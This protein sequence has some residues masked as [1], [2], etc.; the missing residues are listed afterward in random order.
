MNSWKYVGWGMMVFLLCFMVQAD[1]TCISCV[2]CTDAIA[3]ANSSD[4]IT[5]S[6]PII[7]GV[8]CIDI[9]GKDN[10]TFDCQGNGIEGDGSPSI[11]ALYSAGDAPNNI[12]IKNCIISDF[13]R[14]LNLGNLENSIIK[15]ISIN[16][17]AYGIYL[18]LSENNTISNSTI[19][20]STYGMYIKSKSFNNTFYDMILEDNAVGVTLENSTSTFR[21]YNNTFYNNFFNNTLNVNS[22]F[23][24][25]TN[26]WNISKTLGN[27]I[28]GGAYLGG[29]F[30]ANPSGKGWSENC[31]AET[32]GLCDASY[33]ATINNT[34]YLPLSFPVISTN[35]TLTIHVNDSA[36]DLENASVYIDAIM[37]LT[38][39]TGHMY[40]SLTKM[41]N[42]SIS[43]I[44]GGYIAQDTT[45]NLTSD[46]TYNFTLIQQNG[47]LPNATEFINN[48]TTDLNYEDDLENV[49]NLT[50]AT[51][52]AKIQFNV[53]VNVS[54]LDLDA[55]INITS[56]VITI[57]ST[58]LVNLN[59][60][61]ILTFRNV[62]CPV[63]IIYYSVVH[64]TNISTVYQNGSDCEADGICTNKLC[65][66][67]TLTF[68][69]AH[70]SSF[71]AGLNSNLTIWDDSD[72]ITI[73]ETEQNKFYANYTNNTIPIN[74]TGIYCDIEFNLTGAWQDND[75]MVFNDTSGLYEYNRSFTTDGTY[76]FQVF[77]NASGDG[78]GTLNTTDSF[79]IS[80]VIVP[81]T[82]GYVCQAG[83]E[84]N[85]LSGALLA[86]DG[87][88][89]HLVLNGSE[90][91]EASDLRFEYWDDN[92][93]AIML[94]TGNDSV[95][96]CNG[97]VLAGHRSGRA[98]KVRNVN[99]LSIRD[100]DVHNFTLGITVFNS[101]NI[102]IESTTV[103][104]N[105]EFGIHISYVDFANFSGLTVIENGNDSYPRSG[106]MYMI[107][108]G[109]TSMEDSSFTDNRGYG[110]KLRDGA[111]N[112]HDNISVITGHPYS[113]GSI[114]LSN[115]HNGE[116]MNSYTS[117]PKSSNGIYLNDSTGISVHDS[118]IFNQSSAFFLVS[119]DSNTFADNY[120]HG[121]VQAMRRVASN[122][123]VFENNTYD[124]LFD[125]PQNGARHVPLQVNFTVNISNAMNETITNCGLYINSTWQRSII[126]ISDGTVNITETMAQGHYSWNIN[127][128]DADNNKGQTGVRTLA[129]GDF[130]ACYQPADGV[131]NQPRTF[132]NNE[133]PYNTSI[134]LN[135]SDAVY[136][137]NGTVFA[138]G[139][140]AF[141]II[142][143]NVTLRDC[144]ISNYTRGIFVNEDNANLINIT[145]SNS[146]D[147][148][149]IESDNASVIDSTVLD[150]TRSVFMNGLEANITGSTFCGNLNPISSI[151]GHDIY[152]NTFCMQATSPL[153][154]AISLSNDIDF[155][156][157]VMDL[158]NQSSCDLMIDGSSALNQ[159]STGNDTF[160]HTLAN[161]TYTWYVNCSDT[162]DNSGSTPT[163][164]L[165]V[166]YQDFP[167]NITPLF[168]NGSVNMTLR[169]YRGTVLEYQFNI[170]N[171]SIE[172][173][174]TY[175]TYDME[176]AAFNRGLLVTFPAFSF[177][178]DTDY[179]FG[180]DNPTVS[181]YRVAY[182]ITTNI[183]GSATVTINYSGISVK[184]SYLDLYRCSGWEFAN[185][186]CNSTWSR[187]SASQSTSLNLM[188]ASVSSFSAFALYQGSKPDT[189]TSSSSSSSWFGNVDF[190]C[191]YTYQCDEGHV[192]I[193]RV[194]IENP[195][196]N[197]G[198]LNQGEFELDCGGPC[199]PCPSQLLVGTCIDGIK[200]Q[201]EEEIDCGGPC[202][203]CKEKLKAMCYD[204]VQNQGEL[205]V[206]CGGPCD[207]CASLGVAPASCFDGKK[208]GLETATDCGGLCGE[209]RAIEQPVGLLI[210]KEAK[211]SSRMFVM[212]II[213]S[214]IGIVGFGFFLS[215]EKILKGYNEYVIHLKAKDE[216][217][218]KLATYINHV[219]KTG[220]PPEKIVKV[221]TGVG[222]PEDV[223]IKLINREIDKP[224]QEYFEFAEDDDEEIDFFS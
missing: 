34:D 52:D 216:E 6:N 209:C 134:V 92:N 77:C 71:A 103:K 15:N 121:N 120:V 107:Q 158:V 14:G 91:Y 125:T 10:I 65:I 23:E 50:L 187:I 69:V 114:Y 208:N 44:M 132:C 104:N 163:Y 195:T 186:I 222:W 155:N 204:G 116:I 106:G 127:C 73:N 84:Y 172:N 21:P 31:T 115:T 95:L 128:T 152:Q 192:C 90:Y 70:F 101:T 80:N 76:E 57:N 214:I 171:G 143:N 148:F 193:N 196:C 160:T 99:N 83:C 26:I 42:Y 112:D 102:T 72:T 164:D 126:G 2:T 5:L 74:G 1:D 199:D 111:D 190:D 94:I 48:E 40:M 122:S 188:T 63:D 135:A 66:G 22:S 108:T 131:W 198:M 45:M 221:L 98:I 117:S 174:V 133:S 175:G 142:G 151:V 219:I 178:T 179:T 205:G 147:A 81:P 18:T 19:R 59:T 154:N 137:C 207:S 64:T 149:Y 36:M 78:Y 161:S 123:N 46:L 180:L 113:V 183:T 156:Y 139:G 157:S 210:D 201:G 176:F 100:C 119:S 215:R 218:E 67:N 173:N 182:G 194:C 136:D 220:Q 162:Q 16:N 130:P 33:A 17:T 89:A 144:V 62:T 170:T 29:N 12:T 32:D 217:K 211:T 82:S 97:S 41:L 37:R 35:F 185:Q 79:T 20:N 150:N 4:T 28:I 109:N 54:G 60:S 203:S 39:T 61:A 25:N 27:N 224:Q 200:N 118:E 169:L 96:D 51:V 9:N 223:V 56:E 3:V 58:A 8:D 191:S 86:V 159:V 24:N 105:G 68:D 49:T 141:E 7:T 75:T 38:N 47:T 202:D 11:D 197:D 166:G 43:I 212:I 206:D 87:T 30:W 177:T 189:G 13:E 146:T 140:T 110:L 153:D 213:G 129:V 145:V 88:E 184:E 165:N 124:V 167:M 85:N 138:N 55:N 53:T 93:D 181:G 168:Q